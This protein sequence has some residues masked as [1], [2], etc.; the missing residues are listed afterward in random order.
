MGTER[1][2]GGKTSDTT[3]ANETSEFTVQYLFVRVYGVLN[4]RKKF[5]FLFLWDV[6]WVKTLVFR[7]SSILG[8]WMVL[9]YTVYSM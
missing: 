5:L 7:L 9:V 8:M 1:C 6:E 3:M 4:G 2:G